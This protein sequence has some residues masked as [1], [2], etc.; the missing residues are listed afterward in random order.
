MGPVAGL[1]GNIALFMLMDLALKGIGKGIAKATGKKGLTSAAK[2]A[3][4][5][6]TTSAAVKAAEVASEVGAAKTAGAKLAKEQIESTL[7]KTLVSGVSSTLLRD[8]GRYKLAPIDYLKQ[9]SQKTGKSIEEILATRYNMPVTDAVKKGVAGAVAD[10]A[11]D[12]GAM[13]AA[14][15][16]A[17]KYKGASTVDTI[18]YG[19]LW[20]LAAKVAQAAG[21][22]IDT[23]MTMLSDY[24]KTYK[25]AIM[26]PEHEK[27]YG[28]TPMSMAA[29]MVGAAA[30]PIGTIANVT[31]NAVG[32]SIDNFSRQMLINKQTGGIQNMSTGAL[33]LING[34][35]RRAFDSMKQ[36]AEGGISDIPTHHTGSDERL[37][38]ISE[39]YRKTGKFKNHD[40][41]GYVIAKSGYD[42][43]NILD[44]EY[45]YDDS[46]LDGYAKHIRNFVYNYNDK[47]KEIDPS[48]DTSEEHIGPMAQDIEKVIPSA[49]VEDEESGYKKVDTGR[50]ALANAGAIGDLAREVKNIK[51]QI[52]A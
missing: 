48:I 9:L 35:E 1:A 43:V 22:S 46:V 2:A 17:D 27:L 21:I 30:K 28:A 11:T 37:K 26:S 52:N 49:V 23:A 13:A 44:D 19:G 41:L 29:G 3:A 7:G 16:V 15:A 50:L 38:T 51:E 14:D 8:A 25:N 34:R 47:A 42:K 6:A 40:D 4:K 5:A 33:D 32:S 45:D 39:D 24:A 18:A 12:A 20:P 31:G 36:F 10:V